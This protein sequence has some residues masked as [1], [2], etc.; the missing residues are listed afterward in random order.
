MKLEQAE[1]QLPAAEAKKGQ[2][3][4]VVKH[5]LSKLRDTACRDTVLPGTACLDGSVLQ[6]SAPRCQ[7]SHRSGAWTSVLPVSNLGPA[8]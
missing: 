4:A 2:Y 8:S 3:L 7:M 6:A 1:I 5:L